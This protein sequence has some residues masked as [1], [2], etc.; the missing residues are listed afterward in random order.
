MP[1]FLNFHADD[2]GLSKC[3]TTITSSTE[4]I[5]QCTN[6]A[7]LPIVTTLRSQGYL[8]TVMLALCKRGCSGTW[9]NLPFHWTNHFRDPFS[10]VRIHEYWPQQ[11]EDI[12]RSSAPAAIGM[13]T[14]TTVFRVWRS[15]LWT[16]PKIG[17]HGMMSSRMVEPWI[18]FLEANPVQWATG[19]LQPSP[20]KRVYKMC[21]YT[22]SP[23]L[24]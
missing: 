16:R 24:C 10:M 1:S 12:F 14:R 18:L 11:W 4:M 22:L 3:H 21:K 2:T 6:L 13:E 9:L 8:E 19:D 23:S 7:K 20:E 5:F 15:M 17:W